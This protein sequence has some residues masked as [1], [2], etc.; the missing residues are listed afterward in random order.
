VSKDHI[1]VATHDAPDGDQRV[2]INYVSYEAHTDKC[3]DWS[4]NLGYTADNLVPKNFGCAVQ[5]NIAAQL[6]DPRDLLAPRTMEDASAVRRATVMGNYETGKITSADK[7]KADLA[8]EQGG[9]SS[10]IK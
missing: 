5:Q 8:N 9:T 7:R 10:D 6:A 1:L 2:E 4:E 3:G